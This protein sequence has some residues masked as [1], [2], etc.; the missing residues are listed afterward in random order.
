MFFFVVSFS[1]DMQQTFWSAVREECS[2]IEARKTAFRH[3]SSVTG[4]CCLDCHQCPS[5]VFHT[6]QPTSLIPAGKMADEDD[7]YSR[8]QQYEDELYKDP[9]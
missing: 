4:F 9:R 6:L 3:Q 8:Y 7:D 2:S 5:S 1:I